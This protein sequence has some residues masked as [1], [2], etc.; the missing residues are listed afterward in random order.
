[1]VWRVCGQILARM[2]DFG[3]TPVMPGFAGFVPEAFASKFPNVAMLKT[4]SWAGFP[5]TY[6]PLPRKCPCASVSAEVSVDS[7]SHSL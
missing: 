2:N 7:P 1:M 6:V 4:P 3:M 5:P